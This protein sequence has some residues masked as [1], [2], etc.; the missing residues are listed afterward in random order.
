M[1]TTSSESK[2][3]AKRALTGR[4]EITT[5]VESI[6]E[7]NILTVL[8]NVFPKHMVNRGE[9]EYLWNYYRGKQPILERTKEVR[10]EICNNVRENRANAIVTFRVGYTVGKPIQYISSVSDDVVSKKIARLNDM[11]RVAGKAT[12]DKQ[13]VEWMMICGTAYRMSLP[14]EKPK[15]K[16][17]F[18]VWTA[19][20]RNT[21]VVYR[22]DIGHTPLMG[23]YYTI[24][25]NQNYT[26]HCYTDSMYYR[27][28]GWQSG[29]I[30]DIKANALGRIPIIEYP[31]NM[32][33]IGA[34]EVVLDLL[35]S[36]NT[37]ESN[38]LD[39][40]EQFVQSLL[41]AVNCEF[42]ED[43]TAN[44]IREAGMVALRSIGENKADLKV[45]SESLDQQQTQ[46]LK[47]SVLDAIKEI[48]G[49]PAQGNGRSSDSS[50]NGA[51]VLKNGWQ[52]AETRAQ[53]F[54]QMFREPEQ[55]FLEIACDIANR[56]GDLDL[57]PSD[58]EVKFTR[59]NYEDILTKSQTLVTML[60]NEKV[61]PQCAYEASGLFV[62]TQEA[63][64]MGMDWYEQLKQEEAEKEAAELA[65]QTAAGASGG[66]DAPPPEHAEEEEKNAEEAKQQESGRVWI[67][68]YW[69][70]RRKR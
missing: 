15:A 17:P 28:E 65:A 56:L 13:L 68:G 69:Q 36:I 27:I 33:R 34:F 66:S 48:A 25:D 19:D 55:R 32:A 16:A 70:D 8:D 18:E 4:R 45:I 46:T 39:S 6:T 35:D 12:K 63:Y 5:S 7:E 49:I 67:K 24:D 3:Y 54:E 14:N 52:G 44:Q 31:L 30:A 51:I 50:N 58:I 11:M 57:E 2:V 59:R 42:P 22:N 29:R 37:L 26:F 61:H 9:I 60:N 38:R 62:D 53:D 41:I 23:V 47:E 20:P 10:P 21:F 43:T 64:N 1:A 40:V